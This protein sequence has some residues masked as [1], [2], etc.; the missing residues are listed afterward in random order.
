MK[1]PSSLRAQP[2]Q[3]DPNTYQI[4]DQIQFKNDSGK[5]QKLICPVDNMIRWRYVQS[6]QDVKTQDDGALQA[7]K[8]FNDADI[9]V[10]GMDA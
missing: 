6:N 3:F 1:L 7:Q 2:K 9:G 10:N 8:V 4:E 5:E